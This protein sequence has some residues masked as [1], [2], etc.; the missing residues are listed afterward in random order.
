MAFG[1]VDD[2]SLRWTFDTVADGY[3]DVA[4]GA[5]VCWAAS[6]RFMSWAFR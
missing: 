2:P 6:L 3:D 5:Q 1:F 4:E